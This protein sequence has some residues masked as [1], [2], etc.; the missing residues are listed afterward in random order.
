MEITKKMINKVL[1][2][3]EKEFG[4][5]LNVFFHKDDFTV[6][7]NGEYVGQFFYSEI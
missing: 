4:K 5:N 7:Q 2:F 3:C 1:N 6:Y